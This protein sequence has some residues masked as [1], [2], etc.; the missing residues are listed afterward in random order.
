MP[1][2]SQGCFRMS[3]LWP[4]GVSKR[5]R[6]HRCEPRREGRQGNFCGGF[7]RARLAQAVRPD[8][9]SKEPMPVYPFD[10]LNPRFVSAVEEQ[11]A[12]GCDIFQAEFADTLTLGPLVAGRVTSVFV[13]HQLH[14]V[15]ARA[16]LQANA[17]GSAGA[18]PHREN[19]PRGVGLPEYF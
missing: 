16:F 9:N 8:Q 3:G 17:A 10:C 11:L 15:Y 14:F 4:F 2:L 12:R 5:R 6:R 19:D 7:F 18:L 1:D 13:H